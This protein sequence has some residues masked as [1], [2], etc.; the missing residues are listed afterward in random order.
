ML[1]ELSILFMI[2]PKPHFLGLL[3]REF[4]CITIHIVYTHLAG[5]HF[6]ELTA[7]KM[8]QEVVLLTNPPG[9]ECFIDNA[10]LCEIFKT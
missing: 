7:D 2:L 6:T 9:I 8:V 5:L 3:C 1:T 10:S 4:I